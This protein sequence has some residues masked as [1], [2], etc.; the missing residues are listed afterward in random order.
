MDEQL[1]GERRETFAAGWH[2]DPY[3]RA[4]HR[5]WDG[6]R[7]TEHIASGGQSS[8]DPLGSSTVIPFTLPTGIADSPASAAVIDAIRHN[9][10]NSDNSNG[11]D[12]VDGVDN[13]DG[14]PA[15]A[16]DAGSDR[17]LPQPTAG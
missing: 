2:R 17:S 10:D 6:G 8:V 14:D 1:P 13:S 12:G 16:I 11:V 7:W 5:Y 4:Q 3:G 9:S 15:P